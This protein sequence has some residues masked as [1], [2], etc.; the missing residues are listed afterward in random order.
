MAELGIRGN[1]MGPQPIAQRTPLP[2]AMLEAAERV[3][4]MLKRGDREGLLAI[5]APAAAH[6][7]G[8]VAAAIAPGLY[9]R[10][11]VIAT[12]RVIHHYY[13]KAR[14]FGDGIEP[15]TI[16]IRLGDKDGTWLVWEALNLSGRRAAW[17][18]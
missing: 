10:H 5:S 6:S 13:V 14:L 2:P 11:E 18:R 17:T 1:V 3:L 12:A 8:V 15:L 9:D 7:L 16:Q 4:A